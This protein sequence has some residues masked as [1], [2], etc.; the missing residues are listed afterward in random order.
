[1]LVT[2]GIGAATAD[3]HRSA[4]LAVGRGGQGFPRCYLGV[5]AAPAAARTRASPQPYP[6]F[7]P[8]SV[9]MRR[10]RGIAQ[11]GRL[12]TRPTKSGAADRRP[13]M[14]HARSKVSCAAFALALRAGLP[15]GIPPGG[16]R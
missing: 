2:Q 1:M 11:T 9:R 15:A 5:G 3:A 14:L 13:R 7:Q 8:N 16:H 4:H 10:R 12:C 6:T